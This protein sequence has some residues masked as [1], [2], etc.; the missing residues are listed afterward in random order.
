MKN[1]IIGLSGAVVMLVF[2][3][4]SFGQAGTVTSG[5][6]LSDPAGYSFIAPSGWKSSK[7]TNGFV[8]VDPAETVIIS[9]RPHSYNNFQAVARDTTF[10]PGYEAAGEPQELKNG[11][12][13]VRV[14]KKTPDSVGVLDFFVSFSPKGGGVIVMAISDIRKSDDAFYA[15]M[16]ISDSILFSNSPQPATVLPSTPTS[17][18]ASGWQSALSGK[19]LL[20]MYSGNGYFEEKHIYLCQSGT[21]IQ[22]TGSGGYTPGDSD[23]G[24]FAGKGG[25]RGQWSVD[26][27][28]L[29]L[30][31]QDGSVGNYKIVQRPARN[32]IALNGNRY[33]VQANA[34]C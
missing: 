25:R 23:G 7:G 13:A 19:H 2:A 17:S 22:T 3:V 31:F 8:L 32:E 9:V 30:Q 20:Y 16:K 12:K 21:F 11:G 4:V 1:I 10:E 14:T 26:A 15:A 34:G 27:A 6:R 28:T 24:S 18:S 33:F 29:V 5:Q